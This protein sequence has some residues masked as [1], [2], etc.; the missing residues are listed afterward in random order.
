MKKECVDH[1][2]SEFCCKE[3]KIVWQLQ[4]GVE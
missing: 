4:G 1:S 2:V 3:D